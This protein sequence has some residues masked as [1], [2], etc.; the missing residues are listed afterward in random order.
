M[1]QGLDAVTNKVQ[2]LITKVKENE[3]PTVNGFSYLEAKHLLLISYCESIVYYL[4]RKAKGLEI[5]GHPVVRSLVEIRLFLEKIR[6][7]DKKLDYQIQKL[8]R[9]AGGVG[10]KVEDDEKETNASKN[11]EDLLRYR[12]NPD[13]LVKRSD[14]DTQD[15]DGVYRPPKIAPTEEMSKLEKIAL[16]KDKMLHQK[17]KQS[18]FM[19][20][21]MDDLEGKPEEVKETFG[22]ESRDLK[23]YRARMDERARQEEELF[24]RAP[25]TKKEKRREKHLKKSSNGL[26]ALTDGFDDEIKT[27]GFEGDESTR[28]PGFNNPSS[29]GKKFNKHKSSGLLGRLGS[30]GSAFGNDMVLFYVRSLCVECLTDLRKPL[31]PG[32]A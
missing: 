11:N 9:I 14:V 28:T 24:T 6:P 29:R 30:H 12:P 31:A 8:L 19:R 1:K 3:F 10:K 20:G 22:A 4:L 26:S 18:D 5:E 7:I 17:A 13:M 25:L 15:G 21:L 23:R 16:R 32:G 27:F 2:S